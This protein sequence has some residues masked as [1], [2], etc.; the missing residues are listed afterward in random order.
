MKIKQKATTRGK[1]N[2][3]MKEKKKIFQRIPMKR[4]H[5]TKKKKNLFFFSSTLAEYFF[6]Y[7]N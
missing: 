3:R 6:L 5:L 7:S 2:I 1:K 4:N